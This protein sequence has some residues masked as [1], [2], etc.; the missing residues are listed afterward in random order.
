[1]ATP[2]LM[3]ENY[4]HAYLDD[5]LSSQQAS[6]VSEYLR[7]NKK[8]FREIENYRLI[9]NDVHHLYDT[10]LDEA[11]PDFLLEI[12]DNV[13]DND[14]NIGEEFS[15]VDDFLDSD[16]DYFRQ[17]ENDNGVKFKPPPQ[18]QNP[19]QAREPVKAQFS[20]KESPAIAP[21]P[22]AML[23][24]PGSNA[25]KPAVPAHLKSLPEPKP[26]SGLGNPGISSSGSNSSGSSSSGSSN[27]LPAV[28]PMPSTGIKSNNSSRMESPTKAN[29]I[30]LES[31]VEKLDQASSRPLPERKPVKPSLAETYL[32][33]Q[34]IPDGI[35]AQTPQAKGL[36][37][38]PQYTGPTK[39]KNE[40]FSLPNNLDKLLEK[41]ISLLEQK[42]K[43]LGK[44]PSQNKEFGDSSKFSVPDFLRL[45]K[46][47][48]LN[49][50]T[51]ATI[52]I[53]MCL[54]LGWFIFSALTGSGNDNSEIITRY[55]I[56]AHKVYSTEALYAVEMD[57]T[58]KTEL[59]NW[60]SSRLDGD[61]TTADLSSIGYDLMGGRLLPARGKHAAFFMYRNIK[62]ERVSIFVNN[63]SK[64]DNQ[65][66]FDC[67]FINKTSA[68]SWLSDKLSFRVIGDQPLVEL[69]LIAKVIYQQMPHR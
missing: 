9:N 25:Q 33:T 45:S 28:F 31:A 39:S 56:D 7:T 14:S 46:S 54:A 10:I 30:R 11:A 40:G 37:V 50:P 6:E 29:R 48:G 64:D 1:M 47:T 55:A 15:A 44:K 20:P 51:I 52:W 5:Q 42:A 57:A 12:F 69:Q 67:Q 2:N 35:D 36:A 8:L 19:V 32:Q 68:C 4:I 59:S 13:E 60:L 17:W 66:W 23:P 49:G 3:S 26:K 65:A 62:N 16:R 18:Q 27:Q 34:N 21:P 61:I 63:I 43:I 22:K 53:T 24:K 58:N 41:D 38:Q